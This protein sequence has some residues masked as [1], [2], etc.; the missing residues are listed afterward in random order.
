MV[1]AVAVEWA[2]PIDSNCATA[3]GERSPDA[4]IPNAPRRSGDPT[5]LSNEPV[6]RRAVRANANVALGGTCHN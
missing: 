5:T 2:S 4:L 3:A 1:S 6:R